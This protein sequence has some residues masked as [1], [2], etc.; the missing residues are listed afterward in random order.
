MLAPQWDFTFWDS[1]DPDSPKHVKT[2]IAHAP[3]MMID[4]YVSI[5]RKL[6]QTHTVIQIRRKRYYC[7]PLPLP[8]N[9]SCHKWFASIPCWFGVWEMVGSS[10]RVESFSYCPELEAASLST[11]QV[12]QPLEIHK[13]YL[14]PSTTTFQALKGRFSEIFFPDDPLNQFKD[15][16]FVRKLLL[17]LKYFFPIF[18]WASE[19]NLK[20]LKSDV[21]SG[22]TIASLAIPQVRKW[23]RSV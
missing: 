23:G 5:Q 4:E 10:N 11:S 6:W 8:I 7:A 12:M 15:Q 16:S 20:H 18:Q 1:H 17:G 21:I 22:I 13:V 3:C 2:V 9:G 14:P 19:Y